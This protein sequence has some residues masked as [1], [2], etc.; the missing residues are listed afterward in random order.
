MTHTFEILGII[1]W[2][3][4]SRSL[5]SYCGYLIRVP[6]LLVLGLTLFVLSFSRR[7]EHS[8]IN[9]MAH[10]LQVEEAKTVVPKTGKFLTIHQLSLYR[11]QALELL[12]MGINLHS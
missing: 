6:C 8:Y 11:E 1:S 10:Y 3:L 12:K 2:D 4:A 5:T 7:G 9:Y